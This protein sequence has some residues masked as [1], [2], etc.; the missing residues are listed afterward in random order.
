M[1][2]KPTKA[3]LIHEPVPVNPPA[4]PPPFGTFDDLRDDELYYHRSREDDVDQA[5]RNAEYKHAKSVY[6]G[7]RNDGEGQVRVADDG[8]GSFVK[9]RS[10]HAYGAPLKHTGIEAGESHKQRLR[11]RRNNLGS[12]AYPGPVG[13]TKPPFRIKRVP[14]QGPFDGTVDACILQ[15]NSDAQGNQPL[16]LLVMQLSTT[17]S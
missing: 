16:D 8:F 13:R 14:E 15:I 12:R 5:L 4:R 3:D 10:L 17:C 2:P 7:E 11:N 1:P 6:E 9:F